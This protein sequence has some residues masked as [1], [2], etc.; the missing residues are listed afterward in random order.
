MK[1][2]TDTATFTLTKAD[3]RALLAFAAKDATRPH[4][5]VVNFDPAGG[6]A[7][8][9][10]GHALVKAQNCGRSDGDAYSVPRAQFEAAARLLRRK[11]H[12]LTVS[13][14][15]DTVGLLAHDETGAHLGNVVTPPAN[16][17]FP[18]V[19]QVIPGDSPCP[20]PAH[21]AFNCELFA[22]LAL[23]QKAAGA[24]RARFHFANDELAPFKATCDDRESG[25]TWTSVIMPTRC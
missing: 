20:S 17:T 3:C 12:R 21:Q 19:D 7:A 8:A 14:I 18:P 6:F 16:A 1:H 5:A 2:D 9:T 13:R 22:R 25:T 4:L 15:G 23:V 10:D 11:D 24:I